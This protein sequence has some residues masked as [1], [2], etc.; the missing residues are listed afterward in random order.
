MR[1]D[2]THIFSVKNSVLIISCIHPEKSLS[3]NALEIYPLNYE[4]TEAIDCDRTHNIGDTN[5]R[6][7]TFY[8]NNLKREKFYILYLFSLYDD[9][10][11]QKLSK[12][13]S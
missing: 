11:I 2:F 9:F 5:A 8:Q 6:I 7:E 1:L 3:L 12:L 10:L 13:Y 4:L